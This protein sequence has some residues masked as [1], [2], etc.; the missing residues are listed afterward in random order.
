MRWRGGIPTGQP[1]AAAWRVDVQDRLVAVA[2]VLRV[3]HDSDVAAIQPRRRQLCSVASD[4]RQR[5]VR[6]AKPAELVSR[7]LGLA[8]ADILYPSYFAPWLEWLP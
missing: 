5:P 1:A 8:G 2:E 4:L 3:A 6:A 7:R